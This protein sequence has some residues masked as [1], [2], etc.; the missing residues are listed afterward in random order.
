MTDDTE[1]VAFE[2]E[3]ANEFLDQLAVTLSGRVQY[4]GH[5]ALSEDERKAFVWG[6]RN[7]I[8]HMR[9]LMAEA[10]AEG[11]ATLSAVMH[12]IDEACD[13]WAITSR[14]RVNVSELF[15]MPSDAKH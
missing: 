11:Q 12:M 14:V 4:T 5:G 13:T 3:T 9:G 2:A 7:G 15:E 10:S 6:F 1:R 8:H